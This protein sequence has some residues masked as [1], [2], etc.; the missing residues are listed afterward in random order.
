ML[1]WIFANNQL[2]ALFMY[3]FVSSLYMFRA[4]SAY[5]QEIEL[6]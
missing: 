5:H 4:L 1:E 2:N 3:L 6:Y